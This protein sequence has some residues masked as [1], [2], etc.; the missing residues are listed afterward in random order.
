MPPRTVDPGCGRTSPATV[1]RPAARPARLC[2]TARGLEVVP[3]VKTI[4]ASASGPGSAAFGG[5]A[6]AVAGSRGA[7]PGQRRPR[8]ATGP[9]PAS[10]GSA[11]WARRASGRAQPATAC[12]AASA[13]ISAGGASDSRARRTSGPAVGSSTAI[14]SPR[15]WAASITASARGPGRTATP[16]VSPGAS[17][18]RCRAAA[19]A[20]A[21]SA[22]SPRRIS[23]RT[24]PVRVRRSTAGRSAAVRSAGVR[25]SST[26][27][28]LGAVPV[29]AQRGSAV[30]RPL[31]RSRYQ[32]AVVSTP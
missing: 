11:R 6:P 21:R 25:V 17:P 22:S 9:R 29:T 14:R 18:R 26:V 16:R 8:V 7:E 1:C 10:G 24:A 5:R 28:P 2:T 30:C 13:R 23:T 19:Y 20:S 31:P 27:G 15:W 12:A 32:R 4:T 3:E